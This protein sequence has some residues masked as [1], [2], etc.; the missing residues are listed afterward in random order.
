M[1]AAVKKYP[2]KSGITSHLG[3]GA[4]YTTAKNGEQKKWRAKRY[5]EYECC[6]LS[7][8]LLSPDITMQCW[9][10]CICIV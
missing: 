8:K 1:Q 4:I 7:L 3:N 5:R 10:G 9:R 2:H 6:R